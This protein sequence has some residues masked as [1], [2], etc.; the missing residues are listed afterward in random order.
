MTPAFLSRTHSYEYI[1]SQTIALQFEM[2]KL[3]NE[4]ELDPARTGEFYVAAGERVL[5]P[6][7][8]SNPSRSELSDCYLLIDQPE[9]SY[10]LYFIGKLLFIVKKINAEL[11]SCN[12]VV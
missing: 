12:P 6:T 5:L 3:V 2:I 9:V 11:G 8:K 4:S 7:R 1:H 10:S